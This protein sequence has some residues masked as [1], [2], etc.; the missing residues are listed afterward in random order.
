MERIN[1]AYVILLPWCHGAIRVGDFRPI[2]LLNSIY[3]II[4]KVLAD[5]FREALGELV[6]PS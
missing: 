4:S 5:R 1:K 3:L 6:K 2:L